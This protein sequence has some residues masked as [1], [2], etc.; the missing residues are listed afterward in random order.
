M[1]ARR[2]TTTV[3]ADGDIRDIATYIAT[4][5]P[6]AARQFAQELWFALE[7]I[8]AAPN[9]GFPVPGFHVPLRATRVSARFRR[10]LIFYRT[11]DDA[12]VEVVRILHGA[13]D[14]TA[15]L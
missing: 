10:Y 5:N 13:R 12:T 7:R 9:A 11:L 2:V 14:L 1:S 8:S 15:L 6:K 4:D 3:A